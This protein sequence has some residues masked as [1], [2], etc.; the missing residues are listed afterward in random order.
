MH[1]SQDRLRQ[2]L[3]DPLTG[4]ETADA[5][6]LEA[7]RHVQDCD[8]CQLRLTVEQQG[9]WSSGA[10][11]PGRCPPETIWYSIAGGTAPDVE[12]R[13]WLEHAAGCSPCAE[14][15][16][17]AVTDLDADIQPH[18][19]AVIERLASSRPE[20]P[21]EI[22]RRLEL[23]SA[24]SDQSR[25]HGWWNFRIGLATSLTLC[26]LVTGLLLWRLSRKPNETARFDSREDDVQSAEIK[27]SPDN[28]ARRQVEEFLRTAYR[29]DR[30]SNYRLQDVPHAE[31]KVMLG[32]GSAKE[33]SR[34]GGRLRRRKTRVRC[35]T[36]AS[37]A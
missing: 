24:S 11:A 10:P 35:I 9:G 5:S 15:L 19:D 23:E 26:L 17:E 31:V 32:S 14:H 13:Q 1:L 7:E 36:D 6:R 21:R 22:A 30:N 16:R 3:R 12:A 28:Q 25:Y 29:T 27:T 2:I 37:M 4:V 8:I 18:E 33:S 20:W 34:I